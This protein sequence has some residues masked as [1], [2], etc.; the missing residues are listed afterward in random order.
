MHALFYLTKRF[1][2]F[3]SIQ[4]QEFAIQARWATRGLRFVSFR[5]VS[6]ISKRQ[7]K[8]ITSH[9]SAVL[10]RSLLFVGVWNLTF[11]QLLAPSVVRSDGQKKT[12]L[13]FF[14]LSQKSVQSSYKKIIVH[15]NVIVCQCCI[16]FKWLLQ[17][18]LLLLALSICSVQNFW[19]FS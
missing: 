4:S 6:N 10:C 19:R 9:S 8:K 11:V 16:K 14:F 2:F 7:Q 1:I 17:S 18:E 15:S 3:S 13:I 12:L 5:F